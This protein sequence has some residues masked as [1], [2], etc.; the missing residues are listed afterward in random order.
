MSRGLSIYFQIIWV[1]S[2]LAVEVISCYIS[3]KV[4]QTNIPLP[5]FEFSPGFIIQMFLGMCMSYNSSSSTS[6]SESYSSSPFSARCSCYFFS[7]CFFLIAFYYSIWA[8]YYL[9]FSYSGSL[10]PCSIW[11]VRGSTSKG[12]FPWSE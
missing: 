10:I 9:N 6:S 3:L 12:S 7:N 11:K 4:S 5:L 8:K 2:Y 1:C